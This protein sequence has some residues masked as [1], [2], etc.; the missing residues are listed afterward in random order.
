MHDPDTQKYGGFFGLNPMRDGGLLYSF[1]PGH[2][3]IYAGM[4]PDGKY[5]IVFGVAEAEER[6]FKNM[7]IDEPIFPVFG[8][9]IP[10]PGTAEAMAKAFMAMAKVMRER[11]EA[12]CG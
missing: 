12:N 7:P 8:I 4:N 10:N 9:D 2:G 5:V 6:K 1:A 3:R 11:N